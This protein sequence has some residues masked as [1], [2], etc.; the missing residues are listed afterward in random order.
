MS[1][2]YL[3][4]FNNYFNRLYKSKTALGDYLQA[5]I[6]LDTFNNVNFVEGDGID[7]SY[8]CNTSQSPDYIV[9]ASGNIIMSRWYVIEKR[10]LRNGQ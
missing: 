2:V 6:L 4:K 8:I 7:T 10:I 9:V 5:D 1:D 3:L